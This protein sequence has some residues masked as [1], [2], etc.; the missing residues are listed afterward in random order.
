MEKKI[1]YLYTTD[2]IIVLLSILVIWCNICFVLTQVLSISPSQ[3]FSNVAI[4]SGVAV[5]AAITATAAALIMHLKKNKVAM[6]TEE[7]ENQTNS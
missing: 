3:I 6:Y 2:N 1:K 4:G 7:L 5:L